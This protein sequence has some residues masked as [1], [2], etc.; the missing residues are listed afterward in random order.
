[1]LGVPHSVKAQA[2]RRKAAMCQSYAACARSDTDRAQLLRMRDGCLRLAA[3]QDW[4]DGL[5]TP[6]PVAAL[7]LAVPA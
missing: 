4:L 5:P 1:M 6:P 2:Y 3:N 7:A